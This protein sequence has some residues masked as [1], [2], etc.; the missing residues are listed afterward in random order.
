[1]GVGRGKEMN[2][3][4]GDLIEG[5]LTRI[6]LEAQASA[7][8]KTRQSAVR[9]RD[10]ESMRSSAAAAEHARESKVTKEAF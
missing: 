9:C 1:M 4:V 10:A 2:K 5:Q 8:S 7:E 3:L 6:D